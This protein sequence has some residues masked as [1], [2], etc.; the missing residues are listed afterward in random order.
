MRCLLAAWNDDRNGEM[1]IFANA[2]LTVPCNHSPVLASIG[3]KRADVGAELTIQLVASDPDPD[4]TLRYGTT[5]DLCSRRLS[6]SMWEPDFS[7]D[8][9]EQGRRGL[10]SD[11][12][13][14]R[15]RYNDRETIVI[16]VFEYGTRPPSIA[17]IDDV[18]VFAEMTVVIEAH[19]TDPDGDALTFSISDA[20]FT[21]SDSV[22]SW[23]TTP[24]DTGIHHF[25]I[26]VTDGYLSD[27]TTVA[28][29]VFALSPYYAFYD[30]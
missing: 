28:V 16:S 8:A 2:K 12:L 6:A 4:D 3:N 22:F 9:G 25:I 24:A 19:A 1:D 7:R 13:G 30:P 15:R 26:S 20:R 29:R 27:S 10:Y 5:A 21:Q 23:Q 17:P 18:S 14:H 11:V